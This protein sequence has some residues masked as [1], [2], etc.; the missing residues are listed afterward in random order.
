VLFPAPMNPMKMIAGLVTA[1]AAVI[2]D[3]RL[4]RI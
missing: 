3:P 4:N 2:A 1:L